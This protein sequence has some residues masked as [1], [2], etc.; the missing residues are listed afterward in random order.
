MRTTIGGNSSNTTAAC[1]SWLTTH[2]QIWQ[3][4]LYLIG[5]ADDPLSFWLTNY[6]SPL[7]WSA[8]G[9]FESTVISRGQVSSSI[10]LDAGSFD[11]TWSPQN[12]TVTSSFATAN[13]YQLAMLGAFDNKRVRVWR[14]IMPTPGDANTFGAYELFAGFIGATSPQR[15]KIQFTINDYRYVLDQKVPSGLIEVTNTLASYTGG[16]P[17]TGFT[18]MPQFAIIV[19]ST[20]NQLI[21]DQISPNPH[22]VPSGNALKDG[23]VVFNGGSGATLQGQFSI[24]GNN[25][26]FTDGHGN[27]YTAISLDS[28]LPW[29]PTPGVDTL[30]VSGQ[31]PV[32][33][34]DGDYFGFPYVPAPQTAA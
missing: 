33:Q 25:G 2:K 16:A 5:E 30:Y 15:G 31:N 10:G 3:A 27:H 24:I 32:N 9:L 17:P 18:V 21:C 34:A 20:P 29:A 12:T 6:E 19:G 1:Q 8:W 4:D 7:L 23:F 26:A 28:P 11:V 13:P 22:G 14:T